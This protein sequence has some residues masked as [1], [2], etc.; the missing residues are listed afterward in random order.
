MQEQKKLKEQ[1]KEQVARILD[2]EQGKSLQV[3]V[4]MSS[5]EDARE[6]L[7]AIAS[8]RAQKRNMALSARDVLP[9]NRERV[10][11]ITEGVHLKSDSEG[12]TSKVAAAA[13]IV[14]VTTNQLQEAGKAFL[15]P[16]V[17]SDVPKS[18][19]AQKF[20]TSKSALL[21][22][23]RDKLAKLPDTVPEIR[24]IYVNRALRVPQLVEAKNLPTRVIENFAASWGID[25]IGALGAWGAY[26]VKGKGVTIGVLDTGVDGDHPDLSGK[27][28]AWAEFDADG[29]KVK[30]SVKP[31]DSDQHGTHCAGTIVGGNAS[32][33]WIG[34]APEAK[35]AV[36]LVLDGKKG[37]T[38]AQVLAGIDWLVEKKV[39]VI[40]MSLGGLTLD[41]ETPNTYTEAIL[42]C[43]RAGIPV[44]TA[45]GNDGNQTTGS[46]GNDLFAFSVG[47]TDYSDR[48]A[49]FSGGRTQIIRKSNF[50]A[51]EHLPL[52][53]SKPE[54]A[55]PGVA[56]HS[57]IPGEKWAAFNGTSM[58]A[59]HVAGAIALLLS[60]T[61]IQSL[62]P[63][64]RAFVLQDLL[65]GSAEDLGEA[66][67]DHRFGFGRIDVLRA[68]G[69]ALDR[70]YGNVKN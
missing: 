62:D 51:P 21:E 7:M 33:R 39:D 58:A 19:V 3:I 4:R 41:P 46:P 29:K 68:I 53:Y 2:E 35:L 12:F 54:V 22:I 8:D 45:I 61:T 70:G 65:T 10:E 40:S 20:W 18:N 59:P 15:D 64:N 69:F 52:P 28:S 50:V 27:I 42:T 16:L 11:R 38:D 47:A 55:A 14:S 67:Q 57:A 43:L 1:L 5:Q 34:V 26:G 44:I 13:D 30:T 56:I 36:A 60:A 6:A 23:K 48:S 63:Q 32:G 31:R 49:A 25:K 17:Q 37:G 24:D 66:G 9:D